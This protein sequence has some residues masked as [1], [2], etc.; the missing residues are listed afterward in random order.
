MGEGI[1]LVIKI[2]YVASFVSISPSLEVFQV[3]DGWVFLIGR[4]NYP[5]RRSKELSGKGAACDG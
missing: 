2:F 5:S 4:E 3:L 1:Q